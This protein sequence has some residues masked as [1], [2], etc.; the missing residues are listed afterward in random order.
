ML[1]LVVS[2][3]A[4][5]FQY[6]RGWTNGKRS[7]MNLGPLGVYGG[8][9]SVLGPY[10]LEANGILGSD[11]LEVIIPPGHLQMSLNPNLRHRGEYGQVRGIL[12]LALQQFK[13]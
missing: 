13:I 8:A 3:E 4:Q 5:T 7:G 2:A 10:D 12:F 9:S 1:Y 11:P 6:S